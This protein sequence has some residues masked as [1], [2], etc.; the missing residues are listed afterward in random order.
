M[1]YSPIATLILPTF[2][3]GIIY[4]NQGRW[5][6]VEV[7]VLEELNS[8]LICHEA[9]EVVRHLLWVTVITHAAMLNTPGTGRAGA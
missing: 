9:F 4:R 7:Q 3:V 8:V 5:N 6:E 1:T 2:A